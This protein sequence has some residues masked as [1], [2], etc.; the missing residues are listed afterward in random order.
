MPVRFAL[1]LLLASA[2][3][4]G[5][6][7]PDDAGDLDATP[8]VAFD[9]PNED[10]GT[11]APLDA[12]TDAPVDAFEPLGPPYPIVLSHGFFGF[13]TLAVGEWDITD[14]FYE[15][16]EHL[17]AELGETLVFTPAVDP[18][19]DSVTRGEQLRA[20][21][22]AILEET[23]HAKVNLIG[24]SQGG[25]DS[26]YVASTAPELIASVTSIATP[27]EGTPLL[28]VVVAATDNP[29][30]RG[31]VNELL[32]LVGGVLWDE[33]DEGSDLFR[34]LEQLSQEGTDA[35]NDAY[36]DSEEVAYFSIAGRSGLVLARDF[37]VPDREMP[38]I[39]QWDD[40]RDPVDPLFAISESLFDGTFG[41]PEPNDGLV[42]VTSSRHGTFL[43]CVPADHL[44]E[45]GQLFGD[46]PGVFNE[47][48]YREMFAELVSFLR[49]E[50]H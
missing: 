7:T 30:L 25:L 31:P 11:D 47:F 6:G 14:Y 22:E 45:V 38:W 4:G 5:S 23:G 9:A 20:E 46:S 18:F 16:P 29:F 12:G 10:A 28:E 27:H 24:H 44:D 32:R 43:G 34:A 2:C 8:D 3:G 35:F 19:N 48:D 21:I 33:V 13:E 37:C 42:R 41:S 1:S 39:A 40:E 49:S 15:V 26:R 17:E 50:G 36:P